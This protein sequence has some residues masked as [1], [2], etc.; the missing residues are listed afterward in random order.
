MRKIIT[1]AYTTTKFIYPH[2]ISNM[3]ASYTPE[4][5]TFHIKE[6]KSRHEIGKELIVLDNIAWEDL[7]ETPMQIGLL[8]FVLCTE[9]EVAFTLNNCKREM[10]RGDLLIL[11]GD[12]VVEEQSVAKDFHAKVVLMSRTFAQNC[13]AGL[14]KMW[15]YL[16]YLT[17]HPIVTTTK[18]EQDWL[19]DCYNLVCRRLKRQTGKYTQE[20]TISLV[21]AFYFEMC[22]LLDSRVKIE[23]SEAQTRA[24]AIFDEFVQLASDNF[25]QERSV[26]WYS[27]KMCLTP[28]HLSEVVKQ[29]SGRTAGQWITS[30]VIIEI[31]S[32]LKLSTLSIKEIAQEMNFP[33]Q[34]FMGKYFKNIEGVSP[35]D[36]RKTF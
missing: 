6:K 14:S 11:F 4:T 8:L 28:K 17:E 1:F 10:K 20:A 25:K 27:N 21:R 34:S 24:Y 2:T 5:H 36:Y 35:S 29:V 18:E 23:P 13:M 30:L 3:K 26:E 9:G 16:L 32:M 22:N 7:K 19:I 33:N 15:P 31:K 12:Q